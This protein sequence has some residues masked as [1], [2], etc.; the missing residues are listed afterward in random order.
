MHGHPGHEFALEGNARFGPTEAYRDA[1][2][3][4]QDD[5]DQFAKHGVQDTSYGHGSLSS[6]RKDE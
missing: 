1:D 6:V 2:K 4:R 3:H 5:R